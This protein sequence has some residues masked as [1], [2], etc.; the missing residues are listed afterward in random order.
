MKTKHISI[1]VIIGLL[2]SFSFQSCDNSFLDETQNL[3]YTEIP[4]TLFVTNTTPPFSLNME[5][6]TDKALNWKLVQYPLW[7]EVH[8]K[9]GS[10]S[11]NGS[12]VVEF[13]VKDSDITLGFG[14]YTFPLVF[15]IGN[16]EMIGYTVA[17][18]HLGHPL[19][20][21]SRNNIS[22]DNTYNKSFEIRNNNGYG[23]LAWQISS[24][25]S[26][27]KANK[28]SGLLDE[29]TSEEIMLSAD[30]NGLAP[31]EYKGTVVIQSN[32][33]NTPVFN[34]QVYLQISASAHYGSY[35][36]GVLVDTRFSKTRDEVIV[37]TK[38][39]NQLL[40]FKEDINNPQIVELNGVPQCLALSEDESLIAVGYS[41]SNLTTY[42]ALSRT[43]LKTYNLGTIP[44]SIEL[45]TNQWLY[46]IGKRD[47]WNY[48]HSINLNSEEIVRA[49]EGKS[50]LKTLK[51]VPGKSLLLSSRPGYSPDGL[52]LFD[53]SE[54]GQTDSI[55][56]YHMSTYGYW[57]SDDGE[58]LF[59]GWKNIYNM[60]EFT[61]ENSFYVT[62]P[63]VIGQ[64]SF[65]NY[66]TL[67]CISS[68]RS[69]E[70]I[71]AVTGFH[72]SDAFLILK[73]YNSNTLVQL[74]SYDMMFVRPDSFTS[75]WTGR[76]VAIFP[77]EDKTNVWLI[78]KFADYISDETGIWSVTKVD[79]T[80]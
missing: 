64:L 80:K 75:T 2:F 8:P 38:S 54:P 69:S 60:P 32:A 17:L 57:P 47:Y 39:P 44:I 72:G 70:R 63:P 29:F 78:Q 53:I 25:P 34:I 24:A 51:K 13:G 59:T 14:F 42:D 66:Q 9:E 74:K 22:F 56:L 7:L 15:D 6:N 20:Q 1:L 62:E 23:F 41:N 43:P 28:T 55:N 49:K 12:S 26:W 71:F 18:A 33:E 40:F 61:S 77:S 45:S 5:F 52:F 65:S 21:V 48:L 79:I 35:R 31:G 58:R 27:I 36:Q 16:G 37:L 76:P 11:A 4:D 50:G 3:N 67:D 73:V 46:F 10:K 19:I 68:Q 30:V